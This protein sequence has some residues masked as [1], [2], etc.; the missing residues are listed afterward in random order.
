M[1][2][3]LEKRSVPLPTVSATLAGCAEF[4]GGLLVLLGLATRLAVV[5]IVFTMGVAVFVA[6]DPTI[7]DSQKGG[8]EYPL[9]LGVILIGLGLTGPGRV[10][11]DALVGPRFGR[12]PRATTPTDSEAI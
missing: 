11:I 2:E 12:K 4:F 9:T 6:H 8:V 5:P 10:S 7:F 3:F 1:A